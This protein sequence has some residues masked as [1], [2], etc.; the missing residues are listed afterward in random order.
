MTEDVVF[1]PFVCN[2]LQSRYPVSIL[3]FRS[4]CQQ[5]LNTAHVIH[6]RQRVILRIPL[7]F[8][9]QAVIQNVALPDGGL[10]VDGLAIHVPVLAEF[11]FAVTI[12]P[13]IFIAN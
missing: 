11:E 12:I 10:F 9:R 2:G 13:Y 4:R 5:C 3:V 1:R 7:V 6:Q 8:H